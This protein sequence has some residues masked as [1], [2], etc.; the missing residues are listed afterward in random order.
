[1]WAG[2]CHP[3]IPGYILGFRS[4]GR[5][6]T[7]GRS[8]W[9]GLPPVPGDSRAPPTAARAPPGAGC[10][11]AFTAGALDRAG[12]GAPSRGLIRAWGVLTTNREASGTPP[13]AVTVIRPLGWQRGW[14][15]ACETENAPPRPTSPRNAALRVTPPCTLR[16]HLGHPEGL[17]WGPPGPERL[18][19]RPSLPRQR[20]SAVERSILLA[21]N[22]L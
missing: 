7:E 12:R 20:P 11:G 19:P 10:E 4:G 2:D 8:G 9:H 18:C 22:T 3:R 13:S 1:M 5:S 21:H 6:G 17:P 16:G 15:R 14:Q